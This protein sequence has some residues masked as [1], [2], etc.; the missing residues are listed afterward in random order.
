MVVAV[1]VEAVVV[2]VGVVVVVVV[3]V[4]D[5]ARNQHESR[6]SLSCRKQETRAGP[7]NHHNQGDC[8]WQNSDSS[9]MNSEFL[10]LVN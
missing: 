4:V 5:G 1:A 10:S 6:D 3:V 7:V 2:V 8:P 9:P